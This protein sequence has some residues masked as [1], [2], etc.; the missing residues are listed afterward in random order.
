MRKHEKAQIRPKC[1][2]LVLLLSRVKMLYYF[3]CM[4][5]S[6]TCVWTA[7]GFAEQVPEVHVEVEDTIVFFVSHQ[8]RQTLGQSSC[9]RTPLDSL[10]LH[11]MLQKL[12]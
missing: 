11:R 3:P 6:N 8:D 4:E 2:H 5:L 7:G 12:F 1:S 10:D 9:P